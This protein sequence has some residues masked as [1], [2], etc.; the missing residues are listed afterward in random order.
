MK[1]ISEEDKKT[2]NECL[3]ILSNSKY[4]NTTN[5]LRRCLQMNKIID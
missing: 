2:I 1:D 4:P 3:E 5:Q